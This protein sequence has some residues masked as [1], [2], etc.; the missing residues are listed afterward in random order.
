MLYAFGF[1]RV[2]VVAS[3]MYIVI[4]T[5]LPGQGVGPTKAGRRGWPGFAGCPLRCHPLGP[6]KADRRGCHGLRPD[7]H[8]RCHP[9]N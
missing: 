5:P 9:K 6:A 1:E 2:G 7:P 8:R 3:D 4:P